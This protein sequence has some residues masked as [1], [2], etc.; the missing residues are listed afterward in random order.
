MDIEEILLD[1]IEVCH[2]TMD[3]FSAETPEY[4]A[5]SANLVKLTEELRKYNET[6]EMIERDDMQQNIEIVNAQ[7]SRL[8]EWGKIIL[9]PIAKAAE[10]AVVYIGYKS[11]MKWVY[12]TEEDGKMADPTLKRYADKLFDKFRH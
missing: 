1:Q 10:F 3:A 5:A 11:L 7:K 9:N 6:R 12:H 2:Q 4:T 8:V